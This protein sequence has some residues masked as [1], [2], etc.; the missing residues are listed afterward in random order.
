MNL[1]Y[2]LPFL[3]TNARKHVFY[4]NEPAIGRMLPDNSRNYFLHC[5]P[6]LCNLDST[7]TVRLSRFC[8]LLHSDWSEV[9]HVIKWRPVIGRLIGQHL[10]L[11]VSRALDRPHSHNTITSIH[12]ITVLSPT[13]RIPPRGTRVSPIHVY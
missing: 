6:L 2:L 10:S 8:C 4:S 3:R 1:N 7:S 9:G 13:T 12:I 5:Y 11:A